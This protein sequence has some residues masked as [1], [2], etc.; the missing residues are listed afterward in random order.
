MPKSTALNSGYT[1]RKLPPRLYLHAQVYATALGYTV[2][3]V[4]LCLR[5][6]EKTLSQDI[7][8]Q[9]QAC[10]GLVVAPL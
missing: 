7:Q 8:N 4:C 2:V 6:L 1:Q 10:S 3:F 9:D 5:E